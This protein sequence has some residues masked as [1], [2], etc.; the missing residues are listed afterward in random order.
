VFDFVMILF[1]D[2][3]DIYVF[4]LVFFYFNSIILL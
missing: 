3:Y 2:C 4:A 1:I